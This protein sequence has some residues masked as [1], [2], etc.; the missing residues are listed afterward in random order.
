M[1][2]LQLVQ[3]EKEQGSMSRQRQLLLRKEEVIFKIP[4]LEYLNLILFQC[5]QSNSGAES[6]KQN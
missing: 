3:M 6:M 5:N 2:I 1:E 4:K